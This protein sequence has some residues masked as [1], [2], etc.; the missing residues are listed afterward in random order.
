LPASSAAHARRAHV[1]EVDVVAA[2]QLVGIGGRGC[3]LELARRVAGAIDLDV[4]NGD[5]AAAR[6]A[7]VPGKMRAARPRPCA[8]HADTNDRSG[9]HGP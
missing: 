6:I 5:D 7:A 8:E 3:D 4:G 1:D 2:Q 9:G